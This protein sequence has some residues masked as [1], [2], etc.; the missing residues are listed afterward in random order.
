MEMKKQLEEDPFTANE[1]PQVEKEADWLCID[2]V[3]C[4]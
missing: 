4:A 2:D 3:R 1:V